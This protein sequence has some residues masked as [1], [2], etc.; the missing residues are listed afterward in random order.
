MYGFGENEQPSYRHDMNWKTWSAFG[1]DQP[2]SGAA[3]MYGV[4]PTY[5][6][7]EEDGRAHAV[8]FLNSN[9]Q[10]FKTMPAPAVHYRTIGKGYITRTCKVW[11]C[12]IL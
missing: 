1:R 12:I 7:L 10:E 2:P 5:T 6:V 4:H 9:A 8:L 11:S 3:N